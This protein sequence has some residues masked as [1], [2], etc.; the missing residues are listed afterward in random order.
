[1]FDGSEQ[2]EP[3]WYEGYAVRLTARAGGV[4]R[5]SLL[6]YRQCCAAPEVEPLEGGEKE[7]ALDRIAE[8]SR[9]ISDPVALENGWNAFCKKQS[10]P[11]TSMVFDPYPPIHG[12][13]R[14]LHN[15]VRPAL[16]DEQ[17]RLVLN[18]VRCESHRELL[19]EV[20]GRNY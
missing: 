3:A 16:T 13:H 7:A 5:V 6:P 12:L 19:L 15:A 18:L 11:Y 17:R 2:R 20:L 9:V 4:A 1:L 8:R 14:R 10:V